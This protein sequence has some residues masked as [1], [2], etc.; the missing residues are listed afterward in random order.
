MRR[1]RALLG[2]YVEIAAEGLPGAALVRAVNAAFDAVELVQKL[3]SFH[4]P[5]SNLTSLNRRAAI[6]PVEVHLW[7]ARVIRHALALFHATDGLFDCAV[8]SELL[9]WELLPDHGFAHARTGRLSA[10]RF[11]DDNRIVFDTAIAID[12]GG[13]AKGFAV[14]RA[15]AVLRRHG[16]CSA[17]VSAGGDLRVFGTE[18][19][20]I[21]IRDPL[22]SAVVRQ[23]GLLQ[24]GAIATSSAA[25][26]IK[27]V[28]GSEV[29]AL[30]SPQTR[31]PL[32]DRN[33]YSVIARTCVVADALTKVLAQVGNT[34]APCFRRLGATGLI[35]IPTGAKPLAA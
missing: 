26:T 12:L 18:A 7:T 31:Q 6:E 35:T 3:M 25:A 32:L 22:D 27:F 13:I 34:D 28:G 8:G 10:V 19:H 33:A 2:T 21:Y 5:E 11:V 9:R 20:P 24:N 4:D 1:A 30:V 16:V 29:S 14:D 17:V 23:A 15:V